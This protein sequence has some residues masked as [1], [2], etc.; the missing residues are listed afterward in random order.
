MWA[1]SSS[2]NSLSRQIVQRSRYAGREAGLVETYLRLAE[3][4]PTHEVVLRHDRPRIHD[5]DGQEHAAVD[6]VVLG[7]PARVERSVPAGTCAD[8]IDQRHL[9]LVRGAERSIVELT[10]RTGAVVVEESSLCCLVGIRALRGR[11]HGQRS[12]SLLGGGAVDPLHVAEE[13]DARYPANREPPVKAPLIG[14]LVSELSVQDVEGQEA[15][16]AQPVVA[17]HVGDS[18][19]DRRDAC[20]N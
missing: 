2:R 19:Q 5:A 15:S 16:V 6:W 14:K 4:H 11:E 10:L 13:R 18:R 8:E 12:R 3:G 1:A 20:V 9:Q 17:L 7:D